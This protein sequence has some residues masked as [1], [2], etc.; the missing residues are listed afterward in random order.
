MAEPCVTLGCA[1]TEAPKPPNTLGCDGCALCPKKDPVDGGC[2]P[3]APPPA[4]GVDPNVV[5]CGC[6]GVEPNPKEEVPC[7]A[8]AGVEEPKEPKPVVGGLGAPKELDVCPNEKD[9]CGCGCCACPN[10]VP[11]WLAPNALP[12]LC[13]NVLLPNVLDGCCACPNRPPPDGCPALPCWFC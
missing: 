13:P 11:G 9:G 1:P 4:P 12:V 10:A 2:A 8:G 6:C 3:K 7:C 5:G